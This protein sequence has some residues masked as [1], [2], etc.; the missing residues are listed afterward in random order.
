MVLAANGPFQIF[1]MGYVNDWLQ[2]EDGQRW[3]CLD[4]RYEFGDWIETMPNYMWELA[5]ARHRARYWVRDDLMTMCLLKHPGK[6][7]I[8]DWTS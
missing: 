2:R 5:A 7:N 3:W 8:V 4:C 1:R 6:P